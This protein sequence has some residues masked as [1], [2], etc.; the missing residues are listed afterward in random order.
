MLCADRA[1]VCSIQL[2]K[3]KFKTP[4]KKRTTINRSSNKDHIF[5]IDCT[6]IVYNEAQLRLR[7]I[8]CNHISIDAG[9]LFAFEAKETKATVM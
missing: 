8:L 9:K 5:I 4:N 2:L 6:G 1:K 7:S 3:F